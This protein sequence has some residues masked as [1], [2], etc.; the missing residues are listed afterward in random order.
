MNTNQSQRFRVQFVVN[1]GMTLDFWARNEADAW[2]RAFVAEA[3]GLIHNNPMWEPIH[4]EQLP[5]DCRDF[6]PVNEQS[7]SQP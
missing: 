5:D 3:D 2:D 1:E 4:V 6:N 7:C